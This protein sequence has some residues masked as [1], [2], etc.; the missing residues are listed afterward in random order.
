MQM[1]VRALTVLAVVAACVAIPACA[2]VQSI[3]DA[4]LA[5]VTNRRLSNDANNPFPTNTDGGKQHGTAYT[6]PTLRDGTFT[7]QGASD[8]YSFSLGPAGLIQVFSLR[9]SNGNVVIKG[10]F[11][12]VTQIHFDGMSGT[13]AANT[14]MI[15]LDNAFSSGALAIEVVDSIVAWSAV[16][17]T[18][19]TQVLFSL[20]QTLSGGTGVFALGVHLTKAS[21]AVSVPRD[22]AHTNMLLTTKSVVAMDFIQC[23]GCANG[24]VYVPSAPIF[25]QTDSL[26]RVSHILFTSTS[27]S[28]VAIINTG[29][30]NISPASG[31]LIV[32]ENITSRANNIFGGVVAHTGTGEGSVVLRYLDVNTIGTKLGAGTFYTEVN[33]QADSSSLDGAMHVENECPAAC[34]NGFSLENARVSCSCNCGTPASTTRSY[35]RNF[36]TVMED[37]LYNYVPKGCMEGCI[38]CHNMTACDKC[39]AGFKLDDTT[40]KCEPDTNVCP[41]H[42]VEC[43]TAG[44]CT[45]CK[46]GYTLQGNT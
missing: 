19:N 9:V 24:I 36:C 21:A 4:P 27:A 43:S 15:T 31:G 14:P 2:V 25:V 28:P 30:S 32:V 17:A 18:P 34:L 12:L 23:D 26:L 33:V 35:F 22:P 13:V 3:T 38:L 8:G 39:A 41:E 42:C 5:G 7:I 1:F 20:S 10:F 16:E 44:V 37:P 45:K 11:P 29:S 40:A 46:D 6:T